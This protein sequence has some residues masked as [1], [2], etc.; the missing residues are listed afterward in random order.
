MITDAPNLRW[1]TDA[2]MAWSKTDGRVWVFVL[3]DHH[4]DEAW[5]HASR[6]GSRF[7]TLQPVYD[8]VIDRFG[9]LGQNVARG[10]R[11]R[12]D[13]GRSISLASLPGIAALA[14]PHRRRRLRR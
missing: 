1:G 14:R 11:L 9:R 6:V 3:V 12:H 4:T 8:A 10:V 5:C 2:T 13:W 7:A